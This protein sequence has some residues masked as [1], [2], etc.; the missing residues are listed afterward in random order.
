MTQTTIPIKKAPS[1][2]PQPVT[3]GQTIRLHVLRCNP[4]DPASDA[5]LQTFELEQTDGMTLF[6]ALSEIREKQDPSLQFDFVCRAG[7]CGSCAMLINGRP[8]LACRTLTARL[9]DSFTLAPLP[10]FELIGDLSVNTGKWMRG[11]SE[12]LRSWVHL[13]QE[14]DLTRL[15]ARMEPALAEAIYELDRCI[16]CGCCVA[17]CGT[18]RMREDFVGAVGLNKIARFRLDPRDGRSDE[19]YYE[20]IGDDDGVFG[21]MSLLACHDVC[22]KQLPLSTQIAF[23]R[24][25]MAR[26]GL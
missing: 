13:Q 5:H 21:C 22:P 10:V 3:T 20:L 14:P 7:I 26:M 12:R 16:E 15:E 11:M 1:E 4:A 9:G 24:R 25:K 2:P 8:A 17:A 19:D 18:A 6:I 23:L